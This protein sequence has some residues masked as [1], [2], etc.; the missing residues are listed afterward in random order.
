MD[1]ATQA[2]FDTFTPH[3]HPDRFRFAL[4]F[5]RRHAADGAQLIDVG[6]GDGATLELVRKTGTVHS[7]TGMDISENYLRKAAAAVGC[8][9]IHGS[10]L[11]GRLVAHHAGTF[12]FCILGA[13]LHHLI[14]PNRRQSR[15]AAQDCLRNAFELLKPG[16]HVLIFEP[17]HSPAPMMTAIFY[18]KK[19]VGRFFARRVELFRHWANLGQPVVSYYTA[20]QLEEMLAAV[21]DTRVVERFIVDDSRM[22]FLIRRVGLGLVVRKTPACALAA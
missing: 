16:G 10:I 14:G 12:D 21:P 1:R 7:L 17:T 2:Y 19:L 9:T 8:T 13:V 3:F 5:L 4:S 6:C 11:D 18:L 15:M 22:G 20:K